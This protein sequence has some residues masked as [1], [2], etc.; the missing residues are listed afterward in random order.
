MASGGRI[1]GESRCE[2]SGRTSWS[3]VL[4]GISGVAIT[5]ARGAPY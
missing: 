2:G 5:A 3:T 4:D 1:S